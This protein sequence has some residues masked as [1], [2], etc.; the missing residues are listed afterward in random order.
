MFTIDDSLRAQSMLG[1]IKDICN[2]LANVFLYGLANPIKKG[3][4]DEEKDGEQSGS[5]YIL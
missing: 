3:N 4:K 2:N 5:C 1:L